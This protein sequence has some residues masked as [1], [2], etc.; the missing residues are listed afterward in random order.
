[1]ATA[2]VLVVDDE[3]S[4][5]RMTCRLLGHKG[6][7]EVVSASGPA[8]AL[9]IIKNGCLIDIVV[10]DVEMPDMRGPDLLREIGKVS[11][12]TA[13]ILISGL[14]P[15]E[16]NVPVGVPFLRKPVSENELFSTVERVLAQSQETRDD[17]EFF[18]ARAYEQCERAKRILSQTSE[19]RRKA[20]DTV[21]KVRETL[22]RPPNPENTDAE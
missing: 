3:P 14:D 9:E 13:G 4:I 7:Y 16:A 19:A 15:A 2:R 17:L 11:P 8:Q 10:S 21:R 5:L 6:L 18:L 1:M 22:S 12:T 20:S